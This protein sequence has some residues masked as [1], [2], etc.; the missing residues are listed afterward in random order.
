M[1]FLPLIENEKGLSAY[2]NAFDEFIEGE[3]WWFAKTG[4]LAAARKLVYNVWDDSKTQELAQQLHCKKQVIFIAVPSSSGLNKIPNVLAAKLASELDG[5]ALDG[6]KYFSL[7]ADQQMKSVSKNERTFLERNYIPKYDQ[8]YVK[9]LQFCEIVVVDDAILSGSTIYAFIRSLQKENIT[10]ENVVCLFG[11]P[12]LTPAR[13]DIETLA[14]I[15]SDNHISVEHD[16]LSHIV[17]RGEI[18]NIVEQYQLASSLEMKYEIARKI[19]RLL[20][21]RIARLMGQSDSPNN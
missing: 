1:T 21:Y 14:N 19:Q 6:S 2:L 7:Q 18:L 4:D 12:R 8:E 9:F 5:I 15:L 17:V 20:N 3:D 10:V 16:I 11:D 13:E